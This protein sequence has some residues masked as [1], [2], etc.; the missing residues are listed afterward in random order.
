MAGVMEAWHS[1]SFPLSLR[2]IKLQAEQAWQ[3]LERTKN[4]NWSF[5]YFYTKTLS[6][7]NQ[8]GNYASETVHSEPIGIF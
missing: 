8:V 1:C 5:M 4:D 3:I 2:I 7:W 6:A